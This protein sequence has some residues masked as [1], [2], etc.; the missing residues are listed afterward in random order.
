MSN[1]G[2]EDGIMKKLLDQKDS[3]TEVNSEI[4]RSISVHNE[5]MMAVKVKFTKATTEPDM[6]SHEQQ[7]ITYVVKGS[8][9]FWIDDK[10]VNLSEGDVLLIEANAVH[11][12]ISHI[13]GSELL[14]IFNPRRDDFLN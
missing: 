2:G 14:D 5:Q 4:S 13:A 11:G 3:F 7:Q 1:N 10:K 6:H 12:C 8:F 9:T